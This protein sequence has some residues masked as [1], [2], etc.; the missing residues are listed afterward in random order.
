MSGS[1]APLDLGRLEIDAKASAAKLVAN[2]LQ[3]PDQLE[4]VDHIRRRMV[5]KKASV[6]AML[7]TAV[8]SQLDGVRTGLN[9]LQSALQDVYEI[10]QNLDEIEETYQ[11]IVPLRQK[12]Q[13]VR[14][15]N[16]NYCQLAT[17]VEN[18]K[19]IFTVPEGVRKTEDLINEGKL[20]QAHKHLTELE[21]SRDD[22]LFELHKQPNK[23]PTD[24]NTLKHYFADVEKLSD[25]LGKQ[26]FLILNRTLITVRREPSIIVTALRIIER[27]QR[28]DDAV[29]K[30][31]A[32]TGFIPPGRPKDWRQKCFA[33]LEESISER[34]E[35]NEPDDRTKNKM[36]LVRHLELIRQR[37]IE[38]FRV[39]KT[40]LPPVF[41]P[42]YDIVHKYLHMYHNA[43]G[44]HLKEMISEELERNEI[45]SLL[46]WVN[47]YDG[48]ELL[49]HPDI[50]LDSKDLGPLLETPVVE[51]LQNQYLKTMKSNVSEWLS[52]SL[53]TD[54]KDWYSNSPPDQDGE[55]KYN[56]AL[57]VI[58]YQM[59]E[60]NNQ[61]AALINHDLVQNVLMLF[62]DELNSFAAY[63]RGELTKYKERHL[64]NRNE[65]QYFLHFVIANINNCL[66]FADQMKQLRRWYLKNEYTET[67]DDDSDNIRTDRFGLLDIDFH[68]LGHF[69][70]DM[71]VEEV[72]T[73]LRESLSELLTRSW[74]DSSKTVDVIC[75]TLQDYNEDLQHLKPEFHNS[76]LTKFER[77]IVKEYLKALF[78]RKLSFKN[79]DERRRSAE[80]ICTEADQYKRL[81]REL[82][83]RGGQKSTLMDVLPMLSEVLK[84][85][86]TSML[87]LEV[88]HLA[89]KY[90]D[91]KMDQV[92]SLLLARGDIS[93][94]EARQI[95]VDALREAHHL[96]SNHHLL[97]PWMP[98]EKMTT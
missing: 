66:A 57:P 52:N 38:D 71:I 84:L 40:L 8:Q 37:M 45:V 35:G 77:V 81:I 7:K 27:E 3:R 94:S 56:T 61:V 4:K 1:P 20:L 60:Q 23:S 89:N 47:G 6:E 87:S 80:K 11:S 51:D 53:K 18:L 13:D 12:L 59:M 39:I 98:W 95:A 21:T 62:V 58:I 42:E 41:P 79:Y 44:H 97:L 82:R 5:R 34:I 74:I 43:I 67:T 36:W 93:R 28:T 10:K 68:N 83:P 64:Q 55:G 69:G 92:I 54:L 49:K 26:I 30:R 86:D 88:T 14:F 2:L 33:K 85:K 96:Q 63:Y 70:T 50:D 9:Q 78:S 46:T 91:V 72:F 32:Q 15:E 25:S 90:P 65:P 31:H 75:A 76:I 73:D 48:P 22:L 16:S 17:A 24:R 19:H 29:I